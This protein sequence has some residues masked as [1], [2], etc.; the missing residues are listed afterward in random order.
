MVDIPGELAQLVERCDRTAEVRGSNPL[1]SM[2]RQ[3]PRRR[4]TVIKCFHV[5]IQTRAGG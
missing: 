5:S 4:K 3:G 1:L 2:A